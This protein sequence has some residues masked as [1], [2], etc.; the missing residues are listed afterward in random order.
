MYIEKF[1]LVSV[2]VNF[3]IPQFLTGIAK[4]NEIL[5]DTMER[6]IYV[7]LSGFSVGLGNGKYILPS[8]EK[9]K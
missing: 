6:F 2:G 9:F 5:S 3:Q 4:T 1:S 7:S 8:Y